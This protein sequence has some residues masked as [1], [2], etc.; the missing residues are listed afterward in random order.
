M[1]P[2][3]NGFSDF[4]LGAL[5]SILRQRRIL[6]GNELAIRLL[7][8][9]KCYLKLCS[10]IATQGV[11]LCGCEV[12]FGSHSNFVS[13]QPLLRPRS[14]QRPRAWARKKGP[15][16]EVTSFLWGILTFEWFDATLRSEAC[17]A[18]NSAPAPEQK[19]YNMFRRSATKKKIN[20]FKKRATNGWARGRETAVLKSIYAL[21]RD[22]RIDILY[23]NIVATRAASL[24]DFMI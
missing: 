7:T 24:F 6:I 4:Y 11:F 12:S 18:A 9:F 16:Y 15:W 5:S 23:V 17:L 10:L 21:F 14:S 3:W 1:E 8:F 22:H 19:Y 20:I 13:I 2:K